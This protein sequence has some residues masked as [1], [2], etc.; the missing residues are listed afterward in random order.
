[1]SSSCQGGRPQKRVWMVIEVGTCHFGFKSSLSDKPKRH[2]QVAKI[3]LLVVCVL[4][5][6]CF[7]FLFLFAFLPCV[8]A[9]LHFCLLFCVCFFA[10]PESGRPLSWPRG[11][12]R[13]RARPAC[14]RW[15]PRP[16]PLP[17][18]CPPRRTGFV[19]IPK[20]EPKTFKLKTIGVPGS[21]NRAL[22]KKKSSSELT[23][24]VSWG[25]IPIEKPELFPSGP[26]SF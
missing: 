1:M 23:Q 25:L 18:R 8:F 15:T 7:C 4:L 20:P 26:S 14:W 16:S 2:V 17:H 6:I 24:P 10:T 12:Q 5:V 19:R 9:V 13:A 22:L 21:Y 3:R 11:S